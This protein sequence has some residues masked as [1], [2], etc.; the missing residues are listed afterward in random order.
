MWLNYLILF[1]PTL[2]NMKV[3]SS[4]D[5]RTIGASYFQLLAVFCSLSTTIIEDAQRT[6]VASQFV[7]DRV[8]SPLFFATQTQ[9]LIDSFI[10]SMRNDLAS[11]LY[12]I[13]LV[14]Q[15]NHLATSTNINAQIK[16]NGDGSVSIVDPI[17]NNPSE[18]T[19]DFIFSS[20]MCSCAETL[21]SCYLA[22]FLNLTGTDPE[23]PIHYFVGVI[24][25]CVPLVGF[26]QSTIDWWYNSTRIEQI[27]ATYASVIHS[28]SS[29]PTIEPLDANVYTRFTHNTTNDLLNEIFVE[30]WITNNS[31]FDLFYNQC[32]PISCSY[33][34]DKRRDIVAAI[35]LLIAICGGLNRGLQLLVPLVVKFVFLSI[36]KWKRR[37]HA[38][39]K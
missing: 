7:N 16:V 38:Q 29:R 28:T 17:I 31:H 8:I 15:A 36:R 37:G 5:F 34:I 11:T 32:A 39:R 30:T 19:E 18:V 27:Q 23:L 12:T 1:D 33:T 4:V 21:E 20:D 6:F 2:V 9:A 24:A 14:G 25:G 26:L 13:R 10:T 3:G 35:L 22:S